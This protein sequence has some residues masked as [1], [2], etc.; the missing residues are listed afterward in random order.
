MLFKIRPGMSKME[1]LDTVFKIY[2]ISPTRS[3]TEKLPPYKNTGGDSII[4]EIMVYDAVK[5]VCFH[6]VQTKF[7]LEFAD[8]KLFKVY[9]STLYVKSA[10]TCPFT[11]I[12]FIKELNQMIYGKNM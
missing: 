3:S 4:K 10:F 5:A 8:N 6:G 12:I 7:Q 2:E 1:V 9:F 11:E